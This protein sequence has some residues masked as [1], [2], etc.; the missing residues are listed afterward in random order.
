MEKV[1]LHLSDLHYDISNEK[2]I[3]VVLDALMEDIKK[4][5]SKVDYIIFNGD[6]VNRGN[7][8]ENFDIAY[9]RFICPLL[10]CTGLTTN[11]FFI[12]PGNHDVDRDSISEFVDGNLTDKFRDR[13]KL[14][15]FIDKID[16][17]KQL[18][19]RLD[20][21]HAFIDSLHKENFYLN[22]KNPLFSTFILEIDNYKVGIACLN[23]SWGSFGGDD[24]YSKLLLGER[25]VD[26][27]IDNLSSCEFKIA[28]IH[29]PLSWLK[30]YDREAVYNRLITGF[31]MVL[32]GHIH[33]QNYKEVAFD[34]HNTI[35]IQSP[36]L[37]QG[38]TYNGYSILKFDFA[39]N[40]LEIRFREYFEGARRVFGKAERIAD[41]GKLSFKLDLDNEKNNDLIK[42]NVLY[43]K[44]LKT[45]AYLDINNK[46][47]SSSDSF[48][49]K[50]INDIFVPPILTTKPENSSTANQEIMDNE[51][52]DLHE[53]LDS[54]DNV[55]FIGKKEMGKTTLLS[56]ACNYYLKKHDNLKIPIIIDFNDIPKGKNVFQKAISNYLMNYDINEFDINSNL[57]EGNCILLF[58]NFNLNN[59]KNISRLKEFSEIYSKNRFIFTMK[60]DILQTMK[61]KDMPDLGFIYSTY[62]INSLRR[63]QIRKLVK[64]W[65]SFKT[66]NDDVILENVMK[67]ISKIG[68]PRTPMFVSLML[69]ILEKEADFTPV[70][71][72][73][74]ID[75]FIETLLEKLN[76]DEA[77][78]ETI[79]FKIKVDFLTH[80]AKQMIKGDNYFIDLSLFE[81]LFVSYF[82]EIGLEVDSTLKK[83]LFEK[84]ILLRV[85]NNVYFRFTCFFEYFIALEM[86]EDRD[87]YD[88]I[89]DKSNYL[90]FSNE[91]I[92]YTGL[93]Q[94]KKSYEV[95]KLVEERLLD[96]FTEIDKV[97]DLEQLASLP[98]KELLSEISKNENVTE[99]V[100][101]VKLSEEEK[102]LILDGK[103]EDD[104]KTYVKKKKNISEEFIGNLELYSNV[105]KN[106]ELVS[107]DLKMDAL[108]ISIEKYCKLTGFIYKTLYKMVD[109]DN[110]ELLGITEKN[111]L[112]NLLTIGVPLALQS[113]IAKNLGTPKLK[114][115]IEQ[116]IDSVDTDF[117]KLM[118]VCLYGDLRLDGF[119]S[120]FDNLVSQTNSL[121]IKE[122]VTAKLFYYQAFYTISPHEQ[123]Q[124]VTLISEILVKKQNVKD[125]RVKGKIKQDL[126]K[127]QIIDKQKNAVD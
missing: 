10:E 99:K 114:L 5:C 121:L 64:N 63:G 104:E 98:V 55:F 49:P 61:I 56:Y 89:M 120:K 111:E 31:N 15:S 34:N 24:D 113:M 81:E 83:S 19:V 65:F 119:I 70:N 39:S 86:D 82:N 57:K 25:Q 7:S 71:E 123:E 78:Y 118:L 48:A 74:V 102:D 22:S 40:D 95:L 77:K 50:D 107:L 17:Y 80:L 42:E 126:M 27:A 41:E 29:H 67:S 94:K 37:F 106:C 1:I 13:D 43:K 108:K 11:E 125:K 12:I 101:E 60:E 97:V 91:V 26:N 23:S 75:N 9:E 30:E 105:L 36:S 88:Y 110:D 45:K 117:E 18:L 73:S 46:L 69:W 115:S 14:N 20:K 53:L 112:I 66:I 2:D 58:D 79:G 3:K 21:Y 90:T 122:I 52:M 92:Y 93:N 38:R 33:N 124:L 85:N 127:K 62:Y 47:L 116:S 28:L 109:E 8:K 68:V 103:S 72:A 44:E 76:P 6:L 87:L 84:G 35:F 16:N 100:N 32:T 54:D 59:H 96:S 51:D 4:Q